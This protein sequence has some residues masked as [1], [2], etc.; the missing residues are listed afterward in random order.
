MFTVTYARILLKNDVLKLP[1]FLL[2]LQ[3]CKHK[4]IFTNFL[5]HS[6]QINDDTSLAGSST[7]SGPGIILKFMRFM[8]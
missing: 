5:T 6:T 3:F 1:Q 8:L 7:S 4:L 2:K